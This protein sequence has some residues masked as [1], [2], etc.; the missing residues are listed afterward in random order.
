MAASVN[1][2]SDYVTDDAVLTRFGKNYLRSVYARSPYPTA[3]D[4]Q[5]LAEE[6][7]LCLK[8][9][10]ASIFVCAFEM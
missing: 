10:R 2:S 1:S 8:Q 6:T 3:A 7:G 5:E 4:F 9:L